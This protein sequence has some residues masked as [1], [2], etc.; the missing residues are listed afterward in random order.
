MPL[1]PEE[2]KRLREEIRARLEQREKKERQIKE[3]AEEQ[4]RN[5]LEDRLRLKIKEEE[6]EQFYTGRGYVKYVNR[7]GETEWIQPEEADR[8]KASRRTRK[9]SAG[10]KKRISRLKTILLN[11]GLVA[12]LGIVF[13]VVYRFNIITPAPKTGALIVQSDVPGAL[14][15]LDGQKSAILTPDTLKNVS[16]GIHTV[17][18]FKKGYFVEPPVQI[19][20]I[21]KDKSVSVDFAFKSTTRMVKV[22][23]RA[24]VPG[25][26]LFVDGIPHRAVENGEISIPAGY[27]TFMIL[28]AGYTAAPSYRRILVMPGTT[29]VV[30]FELLPAADLGYLRISDNLDEG[31]VFLDNA[32]AGILAAG[33]ILPVKQGTYEVRVL[34]NGYRISPPA[35]LVTVKAGEKQLLLFRMEKDTTQCKTDIK[36]QTAG[37]TLWVDGE[38]TPYVT[39]VRGLS[40]SP[41]AH[42]I[43]LTDGSQQ[44]REEDL[45]VVIDPG[46]LN[47]IGLEF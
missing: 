16:A 7:H 40:L 47:N 20:S 1:T 27:H 15:Y 26:R 5:Q 37:A 28:K 33:D 19:V 30:D 6:E 23:V 4:R 9:S 36:G 31:Y 42:F 29:P 12:I 14:V 24:E 34:K 2:E 18:A 44:L 46:R 25:Y 13:L 32:C 17:V 11:G 41:G 35:Q 8:R 10:R 43:N 21:L 22:R 45:L 38:Q 39:P 3:K